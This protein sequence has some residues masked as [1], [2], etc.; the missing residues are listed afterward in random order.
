MRVD[1]ATY[2]VSD[3]WAHRKAQYYGSHTREC[4]ACGPPGDDVL[5]LALGIHL[6]HLS[7]AR[8]GHEADIDLM[9]LCEGCHE[10]AHAYH[11]SHKRM[12]LDEATR[13]AL[14]LE[15][16][17][18]PR[19]KIEPRPE[20]SLTAQQRTKRERQKSVRLVRK[21]RRTEERKERVPYWGWAAAPTSL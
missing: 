9:P 1:Y 11:R 7:Y 14:R 6:H 12:S 13:Q 4:A 21:T 3:E 2:I 18:V 19:L 15:D 5:A 10:I 17:I 16:T 20:K 8:L